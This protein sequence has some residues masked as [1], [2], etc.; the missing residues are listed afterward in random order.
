MTTIPYR[1]ESVKH[2]FNIINVF[3]G[4]PSFFRVFSQPVN[5]ITELESIK[6][7]SP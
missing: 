3:G 1:E 2:L 4:N 5:P 6:N 7:T